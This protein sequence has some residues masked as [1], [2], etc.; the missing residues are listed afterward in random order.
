MHEGQTILVIGGLLAVALGASLL[1]GRLRVPG[2]IAFLGIGMIVGSDGTGWIHFNDYEV[3]RAAGIVGLALILFEGGLAIDIRAFRSVALPATLLAFFGTLLTAA[4]TGL[5]ASWLLDLT[6]LEGLLIGSIVAGTD[7]AAVFAI[8]RGSTIR[9]RLAHTLEGEAGLNDPIAVLLVLTMISLLTKPDFGPLNVA[10]LFVEELAIGGVIGVAVGWFGSSALAKAQLGSA[11]LYPVASL[12]IAAIA[13]GGAD[14]L[15]GSGFLS[16]FLC[17][18]VLSARET[19][20]QRTITT[21][22]EGMAWV[23]QLGLFLTLGLLVSPSQLPSVALSGTLLALLSAVIARPLA[24]VLVLGRLDFTFK[25]RLV[26]GWAGLRGAVPVVLATFPVIDGVHGAVDF[27]NIVFFAV[28]VSTVLQAATFEPFAKWLGVT[29]N[30]RAIPAPLME[31]SAVRRLGAEVV[32]FAVR[33]GDAIVGLRVRDLD[34]PRDALLN[35][36]VQNN[37]AIPPRGSTVVDAGDE[38]HILVRQEAFGDFEGLLRRWRQGPM[39]RPEVRPIGRRQATIFS[40]G[41]WREADGDPARPATVGGR[42]VIEQIR[43]RRDEPGAVVVLSDGRFA[44]TGRY[45]ATGSPSDLQRAAGR[46]LGLAKT[47]AERS[48][49][50]EVIGAISLG[51]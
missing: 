42:E 30:Q 24:A 37:T 16:V 48:W 26:L 10:V 38:L 34:L 49:W 41:P 22:H 36:I 23:A 45:T 12:A 29:T 35:L 43:T 1:A 51:Q 17:G 14:S 6:L 15:H 25:E 33:D 50:R 13:F 2:L 5:A 44:Y 7:G 40:T 39:T 47:D 46:R 3:A 31:A 28:A 9:K 27:F 8:M 20:A 18:M 32:Q 21:F 19:P 4:L 11:G